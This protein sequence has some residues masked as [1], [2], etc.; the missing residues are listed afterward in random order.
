MS[1]HR[2][3]PLQVCEMGFGPRPVIFEHAG[4]EFIGVEVGA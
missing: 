3:E 4:C 1:A 2:P